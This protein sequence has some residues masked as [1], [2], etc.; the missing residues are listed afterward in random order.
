VRIASSGISLGRVAAEFREPRFTAGRAAEPAAQPRSFSIFAGFRHLSL[1]SACLLL[2]IDKRS[3]GKL[4][5][6]RRFES[7]RIDFDD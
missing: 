3:R 6:A 1:H 4:L 5:D 7:M 2:H